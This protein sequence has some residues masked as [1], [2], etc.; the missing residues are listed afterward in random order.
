LLLTIHNYL[1]QY[2]DV[3]K[4]FT[5]ADI[6][7]GMSHLQTDLIEQNED[8]E[9]EFLRDFI[10]SND[11]KDTNCFPISASELYKSF[12][13]YR[14]KHGLEKF[15]YSQKKF[16]LQMKI[17]NFE[18]LKDCVEW[19]KTKKCN[20]FVLDFEKMYYDL[21]MDKLEDE[22]YTKKMNVSTTV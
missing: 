5:E 4:R 13:E 14:N 21:V 9:K 7:E 16:T 17:Y 20:I 8:V 18:D 15:E 3:P 11:L 12:M 2:Q 6:K 19:K 22:D 1:I 10:N